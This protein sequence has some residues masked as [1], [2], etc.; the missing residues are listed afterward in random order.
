MSRFYQRYYK[1]LFESPK[2]ERGR[3][4]QDLYKEKT[5]WKPE[6]L[7]KYIIQSHYNKQ[8]AITS[9]GLFLGLLFIMLSIVYNRN[10]ILFPIGIIVGFGPFL[11]FVACLIGRATWIKSRCRKIVRNRENVELEKFIAGSPSLQKYNTYHIKA[12][13]QTLGFIYSV[14]PKVIY[15]CD[16]GRTLASLGCTVEPYGFEV[17]LGVGKRLGVVLSEFEVDR[18][19]D[20]IHNNAN[21]VEELTNILCE[22][23]SAA[24]EAQSIKGVDVH[25]IKEDVKTNEYSFGLL[26]GCLAALVFGLSKVN[27]MLQN[28]ESIFNLSAV[29]SILTAM[30]VSFLV[31]FIIGTGLAKLILYF[32][33]EKPEKSNIYDDID[34]EE[35]KDLADDSPVH[36]YVNCLILELYHKQDYEKILKKYEP[37]PSIDDFDPDEM[38]W[39]AEVANRLKKTAKIEQIPFIKPRN[40]TIA[41]VF[42]GKPI[43]LN[44]EFCDGLNDGYIKLNLEK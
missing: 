20:K 11:A 44:V 13:R 43:N 38:P 25:D 28:D 12:I 6:G 3:N 29:I 1:R 30:A 32:D 21:N 37:L 36:R 4:V 18:I 35:L 41:L 40:K 39:F 19:A 23:I 10:S 8:I 34:L 16:T 26:L 5:L 31:A 33:R 15:S 2:P 7:I 24:E 14:S 9:F 22:E 27:A 42:D 17:I